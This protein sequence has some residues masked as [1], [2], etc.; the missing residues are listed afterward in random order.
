[1]PKAAKLSPKSWLQNST[2]TPVEAASMN[3]L[4][5]AFLAAASSK[6]SPVTL[7]QELVTTEAPL[8][9]AVFTA[10]IRPSSRQFL[11]PTYWM[12]APGAMVC[13]DSTSSDCS[14]YQPLPPQKSA[15][16]TVA[17]VMLVNWDDFSGCAGSF[18][19]K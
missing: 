11:A 3:M 17:G 15:L 4:S 10:A 7:S 13:A 5:N 2:L 1:M 16:F 9:I 18:S 14:L 12:W 19:L 8:V 6:T